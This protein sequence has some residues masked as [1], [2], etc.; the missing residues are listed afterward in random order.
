MNSLLQKHK[1]KDITQIEWSKLWNNST[2]LLEPLYNALVELKG[3][4]ALTESDLNKP[5]LHDR[6]I[7]NESK[8]AILN[9]I[10]AILPID[11]K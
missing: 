5:N 9:Q 8:K 11:T 6:L 10:L 7:W 4:D 1:P 2:Y 3:K